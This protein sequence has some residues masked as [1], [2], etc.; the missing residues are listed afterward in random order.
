[1]RHARRKLSRR[2][3]GKLLTCGSLTGAAVSP[4][5]AND[6]VPEFDGTLHFDEATRGQYAVDYGNIVHEMP[7]AVA[8]P[9][10]LR[11]IRRIVQFSRERRLRIAARGQGHLPFGQAQVR[12][13]VVVD[14]RTLDSIDGV[15]GGEIT[16]Q[17]GCSWTS[18][19]NT[20]LERGLTPPVLTDYLG[21]TLG[22]TLSV[23]GISPA[24]W[25]YGAQVDNV[26]ELE[27]VTGEG[28]R[29]VCS[30]NRNRDLFE[31]V[32]AGQGQCAMLVRA[33]I[34][35]V[36]APEKVR[37]YLLAYA[38]L[39]TLLQDL[40]RMSDEGRFDGFL[41]YVVPS[42]TGWL[43]FMEG[44]KYFDSPAVPDDAKLIGDL[45][46]LRGTEQITQT[47]YK[48]YV[49]RVQ[50]PFGESAR[51]VLTQMIPMPAAM[52]YVASALPR[53]IADGGP[54]DS[55]FVQ[56]YA[57]KRKRFT[58]PM[59]RVPAESS[60]LG[61]AVLQGASSPAIL[62]QK[63]ATNEELYKASRALGGTLYPF[64]TVRLSQRDWQLH[65]GPQWDALIRAKYR[66]DPENVFASGP[67]TFRG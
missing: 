25:R 1:M 60:I 66:Y 43:H 39:P 62:R 23:G 20:A 47:D 55:P 14:M 64:S 57:W 36:R 54:A 13:G 49:H 7:A 37:S 8:K 16:A 29:V 31:A 33:T 30:E 45:A 48:T 10:S 11:D 18:I 38:D 21:L 15:R 52:S 28:D 32:L 26:T 42:A 17:A 35:L 53:L 19:V 44:L 2:Q 67:D 4:A 63:I 59:F 46:H 40:Q 56:L 34:R 12:S 65:Y 58:R 41:G 50:G 9:G 5:Y 51:P 61:F 27:A 22:G 3:L 24:T 6:R